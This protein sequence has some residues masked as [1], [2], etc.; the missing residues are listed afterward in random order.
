MATFIKIASVSL[1][2]A[3]SSIDFTSIPS[4]YTDLMVIF[5]AECK[6]ARRITVVFILTIT[7]LGTRGGC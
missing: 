1:G 4:T 3:A 5:L 7:R 2:S 6:V